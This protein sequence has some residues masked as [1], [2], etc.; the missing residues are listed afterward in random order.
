MSNNKLIRILQAIWVALVGCVS[1]GYAQTLFCDKKRKIFYQWNCVIDDYTCA[2]YLERN[3]K[4]YTLEELSSLPKIHQSDICEDKCRCYY[5]VV[6]NLK[7][8]K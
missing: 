3:G 7:V 1:P 4:H 8:A 5:T 2:D 6:R